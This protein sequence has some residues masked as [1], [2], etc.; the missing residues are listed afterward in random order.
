M[1]NVIYNGQKIQVLNAIILDR[2]KEKNVLF[3]VEYNQIRKV[4]SVLV[5]FVVVDVAHIDFISYLIVKKI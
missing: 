1:V 2:V 4:L 5:G 3:A